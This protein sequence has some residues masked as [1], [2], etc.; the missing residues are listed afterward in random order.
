MRAMRGV[1]ILTNILPEGDQRP[2]SAEPVLRLTL[3]GAMQAQ[4]DSGRSVLPRSRKTRAVLAVLALAG[5]RQV[6]RT[7]LTALLWSQRDNEQARAS[8][9][10]SV[11]ELR[12]T[13]GPR[14]ATLLQ[15]DR[16]HLLLLDDRLWADALVL[17]AA[18]VPDPKAWSCF[19]GRS[20]LISQAST[21][22]S[23]IGWRTSANA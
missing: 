21:P 1:T 6:L 4:D 2:A 10:Q 14:A 11:H 23:I 13:L 19:S 5:S 17:A 12:V 18:T 20:S 8:L 9:R 22:R 3:F 7:Q 16:N 15:A